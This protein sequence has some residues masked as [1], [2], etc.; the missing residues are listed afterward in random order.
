YYVE[1]L[2]LRTPQGGEILLNQAADV[3]EGRSY[4]AIK[5]TD[6]RRT[7]NITADVTPGVANANEVV[8]KVMKS[9]IPTL[10]STYPGINA[11]L[12]GE[13][14]TQKTTIESLQR[15]ALLAILA[16]FA[17]LAIAFRSYS[18]PA[19]IL[20]A[21]PFGFIGALI[22]HLTMGYG[23]SLMSLMG[24]VALS[25]V[26]IND[27]LIFIDAINTYRAEGLSVFDS[28]LTGGARRFRPILL[29]SLTTFFGLV[30][31]IFETSMQARFLIPM[32]ISL[33]FGVMFAT[34][35]TLLLIPSTY[36]ILE[37]A[38]RLFSRASG[39]TPEHGPL[40]GPA[41]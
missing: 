28:I 16:M 25:G 5:R 24:L 10:T 13:Q 3:K 32:A 27:S 19:I 1:N 41:E 14:K 36:A 7:V 31:I 2:M 18:Q 6:G 12:G 4:T 11:A 35:T 37:D 21:I 38:K 30:P 9:F 23:L 34:V 40:P 17:L 29:T 15:G 26:V 22:G 33:G 20:S 8:G 39:T